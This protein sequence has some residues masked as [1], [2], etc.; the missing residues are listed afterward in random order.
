MGLAWRQ[1]E[2]ARCVGMDAAVTSLFICPPENR[3][4]VHISAMESTHL[5]SIAL[6]VAGCNA[7]LVASTDL[8]HFL[9]DDV[10]R[11]LDAKTLNYVLDFDPDGL[12]KALAEGEASACGGGP[13]AAVLFAAREMGAA[14]AQL[15]KYATSGDVWH[16]KNRV[17]GYAAVVFLR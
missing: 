10:T 1:A 6:T 8:S 4:S 5:Q 11:D 17:V 9:P 2:P 12:S 7:L 13:V 15:V 14:R 16:D 3:I